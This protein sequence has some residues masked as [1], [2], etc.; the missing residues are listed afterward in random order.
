MIL[1]SSLAAY[2]TKFNG[3]IEEP[4]E[5]VINTIRGQNS[6]ISNPQFVFANCVKQFILGVEKSSK[7]VPKSQLSGGNIRLGFGSRSAWSGKGMVV[8][9]KNN[10]N[11]R[12]IYL[13]IVVTDTETQTTENFRLMATDVVEPLSNGEFIANFDFTESDEKNYWQ[14]HNW[15]VINALGITE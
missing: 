5:C 11:L 6:A 7:V 4:S 3:I 8:K 13:N 14:K 1:L 15:S 10:S 12:L 9:I 2:A